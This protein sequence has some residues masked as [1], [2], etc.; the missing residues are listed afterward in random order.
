ML[1]S[2]GTHLKIAFFFPFRMTKL[3]TIR[4]NFPSTNS[5]LEC[6][7]SKIIHSSGCKP[8]KQFSNSKLFVYY[9]YF[10]YFQLTAERKPQLEF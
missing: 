2:H 9:Y 4:A 8:C 7:S 3:Q 10:Y 6:S 5:Y 1:N